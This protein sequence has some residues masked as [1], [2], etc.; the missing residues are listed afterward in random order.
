MKL[1][2]YR[3]YL[4]QCLTLSNNASEHGDPE[5]GAVFM[6]WSADG[7]P[8]FSVLDLFAWEAEVK[9]TLSSL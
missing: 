9:E 6:E 1:S 5:T 7:D 4:E 2:L 3:L 8:A